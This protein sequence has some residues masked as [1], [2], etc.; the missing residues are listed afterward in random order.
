MAHFAKLNQDNLVID[1][2][3]V[4]NDVLLDSNNEEQEQLGIDF[5]NLTFGEHNWKQ[6]SFNGS[7]RKNYAS[8]GY[9]FNEDLNTFIPEKPFNSWILNE[10]TCQ[11]D[12]PKPQPEENSPSI[13][14]AWD[15]Q[16]QEW[17][18]INLSI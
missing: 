16:I 4:A 7:F 2:I 18:E 9:S 10:D 12:S 11:W 15:E 13:G 6:T 17:V 8:V 5:L 1:V 3:V 14:Y